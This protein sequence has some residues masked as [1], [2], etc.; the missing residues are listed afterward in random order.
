MKRFHLLLLL[1]RKEIRHI[2]WHSHTWHLHHLWIHHARVHR[3]TRCLAHAHSHHHLISIHRH[4]HIPT[5]TV[6]SILRHA[7]LVF[8]WRMLIELVRRRQLHAR[9]A[10]INHAERR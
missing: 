4:H 6:R 9:H 1:H 2:R 3:L 10:W 7:L 5:H 8:A